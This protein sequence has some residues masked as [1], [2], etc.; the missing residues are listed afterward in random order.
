MFKL[1]FIIL[2]WILF[3][4]VKKYINLIYFFL[5]KKY[6][7]IDENYFIWIYLVLNLLIKNFIISLKIKGKNFQ[8]I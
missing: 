1:N 6:K 3:K 5:K 7:K 8:I 4:F 2:S